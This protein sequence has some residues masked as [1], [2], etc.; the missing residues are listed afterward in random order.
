MKQLIPFLFLIALN[1]FSANAG[2]V[3]GRITDA[4]GQPLAFASV[5]V[6][7]TTIGTTANTEG[8]YFLQLNPG[9]YTIVAQYVGYQRQE[10]TISVTEGNSTLDFQLNLQDL[11]LKEVVVK[12]GAEDPAYEIIRNAIKKRT[13]YLNQLDKFQ[14]EV[15][16][17]GLFKL[18]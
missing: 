16:I 14:C 18:R 11:S 8:K 13:Y 17:K 10:K 2:R 7:G 9:N 3:S 15:Y 5:L 6:K 1:S 12:P 4:K